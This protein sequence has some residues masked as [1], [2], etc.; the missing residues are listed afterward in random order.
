MG[1]DLRTLICADREAVTSCSIDIYRQNIEWILFVDDTKCLFGSAR[2][3]AKV[4][5]TREME[6]SD[7]RTKY[8][9]IWNHASNLTFQAISAKSHDSRYVFICG[10]SCKQEGF[11]AA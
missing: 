2:F 5:T 10:D 7:I 3:N 6:L 11:W 1:N 8:N 9:D 4:I